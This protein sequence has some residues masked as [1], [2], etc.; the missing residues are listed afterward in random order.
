MNTR[1]PYAS[2]SANFREIC[3]ILFRKIHS[4]FYRNLLQDSLVHMHFLLFHLYA[5][6]VTSLAWLSSFRWLNTLFLEF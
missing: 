6:L 2:V 4:Q 3:T 5:I 1:S